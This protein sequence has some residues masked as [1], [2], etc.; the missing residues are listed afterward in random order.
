MLPPE[1]AGCGAG[2]AIV[3][4]LLAIRYDWKTPTMYWEL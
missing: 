3:L 4:R 1:A 2:A